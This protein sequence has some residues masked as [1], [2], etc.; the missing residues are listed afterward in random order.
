MR[1]ENENENKHEHER[2]KAFDLRRDT[3]ALDVIL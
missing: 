3:I 2:E 1:N